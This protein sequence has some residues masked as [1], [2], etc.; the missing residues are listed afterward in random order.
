MHNYTHSGSRLKQTFSKSCGPCRCDEG[1]PGNSCQV[2]KDTCQ[3]S[4]HANQ[5]AEH[6]I[7]G[8]SH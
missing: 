2:L 3:N 5:I 1:A 7:E 4:S 6:H 8:M